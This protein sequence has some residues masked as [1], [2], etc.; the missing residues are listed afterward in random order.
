VS[1]TPVE[2]KA[3]VKKGWLSHLS[4]VEMLLCVW[5]ALD[6]MTHFFIEGLYL[7]FAL[8]PGGA[9]KSSNPL[10]LIWRE[11]GRADS[12]WMKYGDAEVLAVEF[13]TVLLMGPGALFC[14]WAIYKRSQW[15]HISI[16][17][18]SW[19]EIIGGWYTFAGPWINEA[20]HPEKY[21]SPLDTSSPWLFWVLLVFMNIV[22]VV[23][24]AIL[25]VDA[26]ILIAH[27]A[28]PTAEPPSRPYHTYTLIALFLVAYSVLVPVAL[29]LAQ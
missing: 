1:K 8:Q 29:V 14:L 17:L 28:L 27:R 9:E 13:P 20:L 2:T 3:Q 15:K 11:Y 25:L 16:A 23:V 24:P 4:S 18:V 22:W 26:S 5:F 7:F 21:T 10:A 6:A 19:C 12:R